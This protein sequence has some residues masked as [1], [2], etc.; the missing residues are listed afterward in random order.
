ML[1]STIEVCSIEAQI[2]SKREEESSGSNQSSIAE[3]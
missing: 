1:I 2:I 3:K